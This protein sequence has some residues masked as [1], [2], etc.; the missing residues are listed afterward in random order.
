MNYSR[1]I[2]I[3]ALQFHVLIEAELYI[4]DPID[5]PISNTLPTNADFIP[6]SIEKERGFFYGITK[7]KHGPYDPNFC[8]PDY[9][10]VQMTS[11]WNLITMRK[12]ARNNKKTIWISRISLTEDC[13]SAASCNGSLY[14][15]SGKPMHMYDWMD[16]SISINLLTMDTCVVISHTGDMIGTDCN[17]DWFDICKLKYQLPWKG[18][19]KDIKCYYSGL[20]ISD[21]RYDESNLLTE[22]SIALIT[23]KEDCAVSCAYNVNCMY[24][25]WA[26]VAKSCRLIPS[27]ALMNTGPTEYNGAKTVRSDRYCYPQVCAEPTAINN[28]FHDWDGTVYDTGETIL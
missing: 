3:F 18:E 13:N 9:E 11:E 8:A 23:N 14:F 25:S 26:V 15:E 21:W 19:P 5:Y 28:A 27:G 7:Q 22:S 12:F 10:P 16:N 2:V 24:W 20:D 6:G 1:F 17:Y 4:K